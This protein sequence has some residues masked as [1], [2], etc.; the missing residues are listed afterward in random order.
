MEIVASM[1]SATPVPTRTPPAPRHLKKATRL[2]WQSVVTDYSLEPHHLRLL[3]A[4]A[5]SWDRYQ[6]ARM[7]LAKDGL[8]TP[9]ASGLKAHPAV[10][11]ERDARLAFARLVRELDLDVEAPRDTRVGPVGLR[12]NRRPQPC[13]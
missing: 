13:P 10:A 5:E 12:S 1:P 11:I 9:T 6:E 3:Q 4:A 8:T 7:I 2:W